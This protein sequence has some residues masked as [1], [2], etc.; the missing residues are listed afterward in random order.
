MACTSWVSWD[1]DSEMQTSIGCLLGCTLGISSL[2]EGKVGPQTG[3]LTSKDLATESS[4]HYVGSTVATKVAFEA[5][6][7]LS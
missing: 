2:R 7:I 3:K 5:C 6:L 4:V 1:I